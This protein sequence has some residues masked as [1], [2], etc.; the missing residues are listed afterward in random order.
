MFEERVISLLTFPTR[1]WK[2]L[3]GWWLHHES[4]PQKLPFTEHFPGPRAMLI[5][6]HALF[7]A[8]LATTLSF[9]L[10]FHGREI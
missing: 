4:A 5:V 10:P 8:M 3:V 6:S 1:S 7:Y 2:L 9:F